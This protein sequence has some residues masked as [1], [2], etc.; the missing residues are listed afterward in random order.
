MFSFIFYSVEVIIVTDNYP[1][2]TSWQLTDATSTAILSGSG[3]T[4]S[5][6]TISEEVCVDDWTSLSFTINDSYGDGICCAYGNGSYTISYD[7]VVVGSG[8]GEIR[9]GGS[10][11][12]SR[13]TQHRGEK[14]GDGVVDADDEDRTAHDP[15]PRPVEPNASM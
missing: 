7:G 5:G 4:S 8:G 11:I 10:G 6:A 13:T 3:Y 9:A 14:L 2:E 1:A 12:E 15:G